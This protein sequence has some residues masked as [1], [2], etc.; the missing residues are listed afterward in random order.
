MA[1]FR[2]VLLES[3][4]G[5]CAYEREVIAAAG[6]ELLDVQDRPLAERLAL[7][8]D[9]D[10]IL[11]RRVFITDR[12]I[13]SFE[14]CRVIVRYGIGT[15]N[16]DLEAATR[17]GIVVGNVP[18]YCVDEVS[19]HAIAL[20]LGCLRDIPGAHRRMS[21]ERSWDVRRDE[22]LR[23][24]QGMTLGLVGL[25]QIGSAVARKFSGWGLRILAADPFV[26]ATDM[27]KVGATRV[28]LETLCAESHLISLHVPLLPET[29]HL[30]GSRQ[31]ALMRS[32]SVLVNTSRGPVVDTGALIEGLARGR[33]ARAALDVFEEEPLPADSPLRRHARLLLTDHMAWYSEESKAELQQSAARSVATV[34]TGGLP[35]SIANPEVLVRLGRMDDWRPAP[36]MRWQ[37]RRLKEIGSGQPFPEIPSN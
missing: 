10:G 37:L 13:G 21:E 8:R 6:G 3:G 12:M 23:R 36:C 30:F 1:S 7:C 31:M 19:S 33:P 2:V 27:R 16:I 35:A 25:G 14:R 22:A 15:D 17:A 34:C 9:A 29:R 20:L 18:D 26:D 32:G 4:F 24:L 11:V 5:S 28:D